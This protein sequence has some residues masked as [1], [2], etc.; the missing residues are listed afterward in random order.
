[1][2]AFSVQRIN[3]YLTLTDVLKRLP[4]IRV[5]QPGSALEGETFL[6]RGLLGNAYAKILI[7][8]LPI[9]PFLVSGMPIGAQLPIREAYRK[10]R[11]NYE[12]ISK[13]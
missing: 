4:G 9:K 13:V 7:N 2:S 8:D 12:S 5:S 10:N 1:M 3:G 11:G 6:M